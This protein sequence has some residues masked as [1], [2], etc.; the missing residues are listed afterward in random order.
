M[1]ALER[2]KWMVVFIIT[3]GTTSICNDKPFN[4]ILGETYQGLI[5]QCPISLE[6]VSHHPPISSYFYVGR[7]YKAFGCI[8]PKI[9]LGLN[10]GRGYSD[11][12]HR[13]LYDDGSIIQMNFIRLALHGIMFGDRQIKF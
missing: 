5:N 10:V 9:D 13:I 8:E 2:L 6:Q 1:D 7:G 12:P 4:P 11:R 3:V